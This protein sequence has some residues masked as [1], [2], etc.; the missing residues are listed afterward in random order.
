M[1]HI[2][3]GARGEKNGKPTHRIGSVQRTFCPIQ[4][5]KEDTLA[6]DVGG[7]REWLAVLEVGG[8]GAPLC[9]EEEQYQINEQFQQCLIALAH[10]LQILIRVTPV[11]LSGYLSSFIFTPEQERAMLSDPDPVDRRMLT[12]WMQLATSHVAFL[13]KRASDQQ[14]LSRRFYVVVPAL[15]ACTEELHST[16]LARMLHRLRH[17][18]TGN[19]SEAAQEAR[20]RHQLTIRCEA[21]ER[22]LVS[23]SLSVRRLSHQE[24][25]ELEEACLRPREAGT[26]PLANSL[27][28]SAAKSEKR[29]VRRDLRQRD[30]Q[31]QTGDARGKPLSS[32]KAKRVEDFPRMEEGSG[33]WSPIAD[34][35]AP[36]S[37]QV[38]PGYTRIEEDYVQVLDVHTLPRQVGPT[39][40]SQLMR[41]DEV[42][43]VSLFYIP[44][45]KRAT[46][47]A[48]HRKRFE[49][50]S[51]TMIDTEQ[52]RYPDPERVAA[53]A[54]IENLMDRV[55]SGA[56]RVLAFAMHVLVRGAS[57]WQMQARANR[58]RAMLSQMQ[59]GARVAHF[60]QEKGVRSCLPH[61]RSE[62]RTNAY[63]LILGSHEASCTF[64]FLAQT[65]FEETGILEG[66]SR[67]GE[68]IALDWWS[69]RRRNANRLIV[70]PSGVGK[71]F[72]VHLDID[73]LLLRYGKAYVNQSQPSLPFQCIIVD[74]EREFRRQTLERGG[75]WIRLAPGTRQCINPFDLPQ[76]NSH[77]P[78]PSH[79]YVEYHLCD[80]IADLHALLDVMLA[81]HDEEGRGRLTSWEKGLLDQ[82]LSF[83]YD[84]CGITDDP[85]THHHEP[86][87]MRDLYD[88]LK[89]EVCGKDDTGLS[90]R[91]QRF[92]SGSLSGL[93]SGQ[94]NV[95]LDRPLECFDIHDL[96][97]DLRPIAIY[98][99]SSHV[100]NRSFGS[101]TPI[102]FVV[103]ELASLFQYEE[104][105]R[106]LEALFQ[107][108]R[109]HYLSVVGVT[110]YVGILERSSIPTNCATTILMAQ[111]AASLDLVQKIFHLGEA[112]VQ[113]LR[114]FGK[115]EALLLMGE[116][117]VAVR[118]L[119]SESEYRI[120]T[121]DQDFGPLLE[122]TNQKWDGRLSSCSR[123]V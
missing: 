32:R 65:L 119:A 66:M 28:R 42:M 9:S 55:A 20:A 51:S 105:R 95:A 52:D 48:L 102:V 36:A 98:L 34:R 106:F 76:T 114:T 91:L 87:L 88:I 38:S 97:T 30:E 78:R 68:P 31:D 2:S 40:F 8:R 108:A 17:Q 25:I 89:S 120:A 63:P 104:G 99:L 71:T 96:P 109:K 12:T 75:E 123:G 21:L 58:I 53:Q 74:I 79:Q 122:S 85:A 62:L 118:F 22:Q 103:D 47:R 50:H 107:R 64:P 94:T 10:P 83:A 60:E 15:G 46:M 41:I 111:E 81:E 5:V 16:A 4:E 6:L 7:T 49:M 27:G 116:Q 59:L 24:L 93:F 84:L 117:H 69:K 13:G 3:P 90:D 1:K 33:P 45:P 14:L 80:K 54:D 86:P 70:G 100:W 37:I 44:Q 61:A 82:A 11:D 23:M 67:T 18:G 112:E 113:E 73:R 29:E 110:Q 92:V 57:I 19:S 121:S 43:D 56:D 39:W 115:G 77:A 26:S 101:T 35:I 72:K